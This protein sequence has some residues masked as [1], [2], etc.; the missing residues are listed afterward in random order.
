MLTHDP[1]WS[2]YVTL[3]GTACFVIY[4]FGELQYV[5]FELFSSFRGNFTLAFVSEE[6]DLQACD[7]TPGYTVFIL[8]I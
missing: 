7:I 3:M 5:F 8:S 6:L 1:G 4:P 2:E